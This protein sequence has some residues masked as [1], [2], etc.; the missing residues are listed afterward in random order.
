MV[1]NMD[2]E[3]IALLDNQIEKEYGKME[4]E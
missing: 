4:K 2:W 1:N 3:Y